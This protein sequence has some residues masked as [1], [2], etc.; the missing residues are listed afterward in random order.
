MRVPTR[1]LRERRQRPHENLAKD[2]FELDGSTSAAASGEARLLPMVAIVGRPNVGKSTLFNRIL[3][4]RKAVVHDRPGVTRDR[5]IDQTEWEGTPFLCVDTGGFDVRL[6]DPLL[7]GVV[8]Q[9]RLAIDEADVILFLTAVGESD[10]PAE[11]V[12]IDRLR[13]SRKPVLVAVNKCDKAAQALE[14][15]EFFR[16]GFDRIRPISALHGVGVGDLLS[17]LVAAVR[18]LEQ[19]PRHAFGG[20]GGIRL[21]IVGRQNV[22]KS[23]LVNRLAGAE[24]VLASELPGTTRDAIDTVVRTPDGKVFTLID[25]AGIRRR[26]K[27]EIGIEKLS[28][29]SAMMSLRR[30]DVAAVL[31]DGAQGLTEQDAHIAGYCVDAGLALMILV[32]K[33]D[34]VEKDHR[35]ADQFTK[36]L[37][38]EW[39]FIRFAPVLYLSGLTGQ[40][41]NRIFEVAERVHANATRRIGTHEL[42]ERLVEWVGA[43][44]PA[45]SKNRRPKVRFLRQT[46]V[47]PPTFT[48]FVNDPALFHFSYQRYIVNRLREAYD[49]EG[50]P[51]RLELRRNRRARA[52]DPDVAIDA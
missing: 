39:A 5:N 52:G 3:G 44:P 17:D 37:E 28:V 14:A 47:Q 30:A 11:Q 33:W 19:P 13:A 21:A 15:G 1:K 7:D 2:V 45:M 29:L 51:M 49:F 50:T 34:L 10:H 9:V 12:I 8:E 18:A 20:P 6:D 46:A 42:N 48:L 24:R 32:N 4:R 22:G 27:V 36:T 31:V 43:R 38:R 41:T 35:T 40:R 23:T 16:F 26:G 25:T